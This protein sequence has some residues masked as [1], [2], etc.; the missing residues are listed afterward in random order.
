M[1]VCVLWG[2]SGNITCGFQGGVNVFTFCSEGG[3]KIGKV[4]QDLSPPPTH[5]HTDT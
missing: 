2:W 5:T 1:F 4:D 3:G